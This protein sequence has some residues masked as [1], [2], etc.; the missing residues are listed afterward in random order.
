MKPVPQGGYVPLDKAPL[1]ALLFCSSLTVL[2]ETGEVIFKTI[3][4]VLNEVRKQPIHVWEML[5]RILHQCQSIG[6]GGRVI[7]ASI[8]GENVLGRLRNGT[9]QV[10]GLILLQKVGRQ[11][12]VNLDVNLHVSLSC[13]CHHSTVHIAVHV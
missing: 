5:N 11:Q 7:R 12:R 13:F 6:F 8:R 4:P 10:Y 3:S 2:A 1:I 9:V